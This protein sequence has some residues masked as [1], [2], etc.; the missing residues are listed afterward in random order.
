MWRRGARYDIGS[1]TQHSST[2]KAAR[3]CPDIS[4]RSRLAHTVPDRPACAAV[5]GVLALVYPNVSKPAKTSDNMP[6]YM[7]RAMYVAGSVVYTL[8]SSTT[9]LCEHTWAQRVDLL[10]MRRVHP[11]HTTKAVPASLHSSSAHPLP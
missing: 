2:S 3:V 5:D 9:C 1:P 10:V 6:K 11:P 8:L 4:G 7:I